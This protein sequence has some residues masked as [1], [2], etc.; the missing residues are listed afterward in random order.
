MFLQYIGCFISNCIFYLSGIYI[1]LFY[2]M[3]RHC[4][5]YKDEVWINTGV[6]FN[7]LG[8]LER[9]IYFGQEIE[10]WHICYK[11]ENYN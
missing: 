11:V 6:F 1:S 7:R 10:I 9:P 5:F 3:R 4:L 8:S 2:E